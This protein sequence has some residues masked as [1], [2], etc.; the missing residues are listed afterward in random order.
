VADLAEWLAG[1]GLGKYAAAFA[2]Q[3]IDFDLLP[4]LTEADVRELGLPIGPR[5]KL[6]EAI[7]ALRGATPTRDDKPERP[8]EAERRQLTIMFVDLANST[9]LA[10]RLDPEAMREVL[11]AFQDAV[12][13][14]IGRLGYVAKLMGDGVLAYFGWP[15]AHEDDAERA[16][17]AAL[18]ITDAVAR[19]ASPIGEKLACR[20]GIAT[21]LVVVGDLIGAGAAQE[22]A[23]VGPTPN[24]AARLQEAAGPGEVMIAETTRR[25]LGSGFVV[26]AI[27]ER[28]LKG[29]PQPVPLFR[30][31][32]REPRGS[33][34]GARAEADLGPMIG[35]EAEVAALR[36]A[37]EQAKSGSGQAVLLTGEA[38]IGKSRLLQTLDAS[39]AED[40][41]ARQV[42]QCSPLHSD[43]PFWPVVQQFAP[44]AAIVERGMDEADGRDRRQI[45]RET[46]DALA[47]QLLDTA[48]AGPALVVFEDAQWADRATVELMRH[49]A[50]AVADVPVLMI[51]TSRPE[52][53]P[54]LGKGA[55]LIRLALPR[56]DRPAAGALVAAIAG[57]HQLA[58]RLGSE[59]LA[60]SDGIPLFIEEMTRAVI[61]TAPAG[62]AVSVPATLRDSLIARLDVSPAMKAAAQ[63]AA[64]IGRDFDEALL[65]SIADIEPVE[66]REGL[67]AL[68]QAG[69]VLA[70]AG[71]RL[72]F[73]HALLCDIAYETLLRPRR[74][75]LHHRIAEALEAMPAN[76]AEREPES[77]AHHWFAAGQDGRA[78]IY[79]LRARHRV[80]HWQEQL[81]ALAD[82]LDADTAE[83]IPIH[84]GPGVRQLH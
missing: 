33:R 46:I 73:K 44:A 12:T 29:H 37:W 64:C 77:L 26:E 57:R 63:I 31:L 15:R 70:Q 25:L 9:P 49:L 62:E 28:R 60:R 34:F 48:R 75:K 83:V 4:L 22:H 5:R 84:G 16:V 67:S 68:L 47:G 32:R 55:N 21:G 61:E 81:D 30:V 35:R 20:V 36:R 54:R 78:E 24:L 23:V 43:N 3:E 76:L 52:G 51:V 59:I 79:W 18:A 11:R 74:Q 42:F 38:G 8:S 2:E 45:R 10:L 56:L 7:A 1:L 53:E 40:K 6:L 65:L 50:G 14:E 69:H 72:R 27:G 58:A 17:A 19:L 80:A 82:Y 13:G 41:M 39:V 66:L 71:G